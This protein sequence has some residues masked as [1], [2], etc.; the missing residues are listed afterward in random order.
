M[1]LCGSKFV[2]AILDRSDLSMADL[3][4]ANLQ[5]AS[6]RDAVLLGTILVRADLREAN[7][8]GAILSPI[9][10]RGKDGRPTGRTMATN[11]EDANLIGVNLAGFELSECLTSGAKLTQN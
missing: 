3:S 6:L 11:L 10:L 1:K 5:K 9:Q 7:L 8:D 2:G 4:D